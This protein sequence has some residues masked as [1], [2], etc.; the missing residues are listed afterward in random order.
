MQA[1]KDPDRVRGVLYSAPSYDHVASSSGAR[2]IAWPPFGVPA[3]GVSQAIT[4][5]I[6]I[7]VVR[8]ALRGPQRIDG[9][10]RVELDGPRHER[11]RLHREPDNVIKPPYQSVCGRHGIRTD[12]RNTGQVPRDI[13][14]NAC[15]H[16][17]RGRAR[18]TAI[19]WHATLF[20]HVKSAKA[21]GSGFPAGAACVG[22]A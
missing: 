11:V 7:V 18:R 12:A 21:N 20:S 8:V 14:L 22:G 1:P 9:T 4:R 17:L 16:E 2:R 19:N 6:P 5:A 13:R 15:G 3:V 10:A